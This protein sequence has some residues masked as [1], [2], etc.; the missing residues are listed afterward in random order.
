MSRWFDLESRVGHETI[1]IVNAPHWTDFAV[2]QSD[3]LTE[4]VGNEPDE[5]VLTL[6]WTPPV[7]E[8]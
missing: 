5:A 3:V 2:G 7:T 8:Q 1:A 4:E 6:N